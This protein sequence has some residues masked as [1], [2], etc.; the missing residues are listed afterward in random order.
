MPGGHPDST[1][2]NELRCGQRLAGFNCRNPTWV[3]CKPDLRSGE[4]HRD[5]TTEQAPFDAWW[6]KGRCHLSTTTANLV[7]D[8]WCGSQ[9]GKVMLTRTLQASMWQGSRHCSNHV[10]TLR[11][12]ALYRYMSSQILQEWQDVDPMRHRSGCFKGPRAQGPGSVHPLENGLFR[13]MPSFET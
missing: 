11:L 6:P 1:S 10:G 9:Q 7:T 13:N 4:W 2:S 3:I 8:G 5:T 12:W